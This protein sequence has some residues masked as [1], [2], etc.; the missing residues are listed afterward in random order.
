MTR[1]TGRGDRWWTRGFAL[2]GLAVCFFLPFGAIGAIDV[3]YTSSVVVPHHRPSGAQNGRQ[4]ANRLNR[5][6]ATQ[7]ELAGRSADPIAGR[8]IGP[9]AV[10]VTVP[11]ALLVLAALVLLGLLVDRPPALRSR[12]AV[13]FPA[14]RGPPAPC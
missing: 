1:S 10:G 6:T 5:A 2:L 14:P 13:A 8:S 4:V 7:V 9:G 3:S 12:L 11:A